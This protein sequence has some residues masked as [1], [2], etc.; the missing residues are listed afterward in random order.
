MADRRMFALTVIDSDA[1]LEMPASTQS[2]YFH[3]G[4]RADDDGFINN[5]IKIQRSVGSSN[6]DLKLLIAKNFIL[7][8]DSGVIVIKHWRMHNYIRKDRYKE[9]NYL[10]EKGQLTLK[11]N[12]SYTINNTV[13]I[14]LDNQMSTVGQPSIGK[15]R[16]GKVNKDKE[17][18]KIAYAP[19]VS[20][21]QD[22]YDTLVS[23]HGEEMVRLMIKKLD[24]YKGAS[25]RTYKSDYRAI[26]SWVVDEIIGKKSTQPTNQ[27][28][29][30]EKN[31]C[32]END[33]L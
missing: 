32:D 1:F 6:D 15:D 30:V 31:Y 11:T 33:F 17:D 4:M 8:F 29:V 5:P 16:L 23:T 3:L 9:T 21:K 13:G 28:N 20:L 19:Y 14:P 7:P 22:E 12:G 2:L 26:L 24:N 25:G 18:A 27:K 10:E